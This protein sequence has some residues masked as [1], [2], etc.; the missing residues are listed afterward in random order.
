MKAFTVS[1]LTG[2]SPIELGMSRAEVHSA[3]GKPQVSFHKVADSRSPTDAWYENGFQVFYS[4]EDFTV[5]Y[6]ELSRDSGFAAMLFGTDVFNTPVDDLV[7][8]VQERAA[9]DET[10]SEPGFSY[11]FPAME[12]SFWR[13]V[14]EAPEGQFFSTI[15]VGVTGYYSQRNDA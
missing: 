7:A 11:I 3:L 12:L 15:G 4:D 5:E 14:P 6:I 8:R 10:G 13:P 2:V 1:P 9:L